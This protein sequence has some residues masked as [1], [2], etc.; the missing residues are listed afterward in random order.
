MPYAWERQSGSNNSRVKLNIHHKTQYMRQEVGNR[1]VCCYFPREF[2]SLS[3]DSGR[4]FCSDS[5]SEALLSF[6][7]S[8]QQCDIRKTTRDAETEHA[9]IY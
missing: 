9:R 8:W 2:L 1:K 3:Q 4:Q 7:A 6:L 5:H